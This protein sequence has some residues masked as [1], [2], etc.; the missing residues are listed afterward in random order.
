MTAEERLRAGSYLCGAIVFSDECVFRL[1]KALPERAVD[2][3]SAL[4]EVEQL[5]RER[6]EARAEVAK[7]RDVEAMLMDA[8]QR[9]ARL[10][11]AVNRGRPYP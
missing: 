4:E 8:E 9:I 6:D 7:L 11:S 1:E 10:K 5:T 3:S 2:L